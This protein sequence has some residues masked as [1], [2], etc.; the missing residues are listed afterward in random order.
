MAH[1]WD[2]SRQEERYS[3]HIGVSLLYLHHAKLTNNNYYSMAMIHHNNYEF[4]M[5][6][7][8]QIEWK[9]W[10][11]GRISGLNLDQWES[12]ESTYS[13]ASV[14]QFTI[15]WWSDYIDKLVNI[16]Y[17]NSMISTQWCQHVVLLSSAVLNS[18]RFGSMRCPLYNYCFELLLFPWYCLCHL[19]TE[20][21]IVPLIMPLLNWNRE[22][23]FS[24]AAISRL[25]S[26]GETSTT[27]AGRRLEGSS[28]INEG[29]TS[30]LSGNSR[31]FLF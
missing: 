15:D 10:C 18:N 1:W 4:I 19:M 12:P 3:S 6:N 9:Y 22:P 17:D 24:A 7:D 31:L 23:R 8:E 14:A 30:S 16:Q 13:R 26:R 27:I 11:R 20:W 25:C 2:R 29:V 21:A 28:A 5:M